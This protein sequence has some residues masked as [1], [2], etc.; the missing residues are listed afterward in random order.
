LALVTLP[1]FPANILEIEKT[2]GAD[3]FFFLFFHRPTKAER[4]P[5]VEKTVGSCFERIWIS[6]VVHHLFMGP[7]AVPP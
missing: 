5:W 1:R 3:L 2:A 6:E 7:W 4:K